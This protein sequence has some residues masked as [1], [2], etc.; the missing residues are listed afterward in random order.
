MTFRPPTEP[1]YDER[2]PAEPMP[3]LP[4]RL[5]NIY[6]KLLIE[7]FS[8]PQALKDRVE[9]IRSAR[10]AEQVKLAREAYMGLPERAA[11]HEAEDRLRIAEDT[12]AVG[13]N[14]LAKIRE[15]LSDPELAEE[16][17]AKLLK[18]Q[19]ELT[20]KIQA[21]EIRV[22]ALKEQL[23][24][25]KIDFEAAFFDKKRA[26]ADAYR[27]DARAREVATYE[28]LRAALFQ[29]PE[30]EAALAARAP[31]D[32]YQPLLWQTKVMPTVSEILSA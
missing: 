11:V 6:G 5:T 10:V 9:A 29:M 21:M 16:E 15:Q 23:A 12:L 3:D 7:L 26:L 30:L 19:G 17:I 22:G 2:P 25:K 8:V 31:D 18:R 4:L 24:G 20:I 32:P 14:A 27:K 13:L 28:S 1:V